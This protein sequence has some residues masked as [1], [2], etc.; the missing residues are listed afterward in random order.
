VRTAL[1]LKNIS[2]SYRA[3]ALLPGEH[4]SEMYLKLNPQGL[5]P[6]LEIKDKDVLTQSM[7]II[8]YLDETVPSPPLLPSTPLGRA[9]VRALAQIIGCDIHPLNNLRVL[10]TLKSEFGADTKAVSA[11]FSTWVHEGFRAFETR[12]QETETGE[13]CHGDTPGLADICLFSQVLNNVRFDVDM[14]AYPT[15]MRIHKNCESLSAFQK[16]IPALQ[17]DAP[18]KVT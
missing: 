7:A 6:A 3:Y 4:K 12:L 5:V 15:I 10:Q 8:E 16:S 13:F 1:H 11:W 18:Q 9:R 17:P 2:F 14:G